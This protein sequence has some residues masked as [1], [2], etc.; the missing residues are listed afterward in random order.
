MN[1]VKSLFAKF[2]DK[3]L[4]ELFVFDLDFTLW[5]FWVDTHVYPPFDKDQHGNVA[6]RFKTSMK[7]YPG[8]KEI[9]LNLQSLGVRMAAA[10]RT[11]APK[12]ANDF[13]KL[14]GIDRHF[15]LKEIYPGCKLAHFQKFH[16]KSGIEYQ[17]MIF[18]DDEHRNIEDINKLGVTC[19]YV[20]N[21][22]NM[23]CIEQGLRQYRKNQHGNRN[24]VC[25]LESD[26]SA[27]TLT[28]F[29]SD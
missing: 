22:L 4:P 18:F 24:L 17:K 21:G 15:Y 23:S 25:Q 9:L 13:M 29:A 16:E 12:E 3:E 8:V 28:Y 7:L 10:S 20:G 6:D 19:V 26:L 5:P 2:T 1:S 11:E 27:G 14:I